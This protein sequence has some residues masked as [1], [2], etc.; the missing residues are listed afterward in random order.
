M[1]DANG[2]FKG[3]A[4]PRLPWKEPVRCD[5]CDLELPRDEAVEVTVVARESESTVYYCGM[6]GGDLT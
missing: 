5:L 1:P 3:I 4:V 2:R 6:C